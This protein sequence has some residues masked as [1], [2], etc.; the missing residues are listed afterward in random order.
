MPLQLGDVC[1]LDADPSLWKSPGDRAPWADAHEMLPHSDH[2]LNREIG[3]LNFRLGAQNRVATCPQ[4]HDQLEDKDF[5]AEG[6]LITQVRAGCGDPSSRR[7]DA[8]IVPTGWLAGVCPTDTYANNV[9]RT[10]TSV[11]APKHQAFMN[12]TR[13]GTGTAADHAAAHGGCSRR[14]SSL[15]R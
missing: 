1:G 6:G 8:A 11:C 5:A 10:E 7:H 3:R 4:W 9:V 2:V 14:P 15:G 13:R 12:Q